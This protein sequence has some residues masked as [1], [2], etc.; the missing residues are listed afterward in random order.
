MGEEA[1]AM[2]ADHDGRPALGTA[3][4]T[5]VKSGSFFVAL[6]LIP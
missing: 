3:Y 4:A 5:G 6:D 1:A 2:P